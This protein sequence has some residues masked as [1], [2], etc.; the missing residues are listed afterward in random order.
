MG[1]CAS[2]QTPAEGITKAKPSRSQL[3]TTHT[4]PSTQQSASKPLSSST[5]RRRPTSVNAY[6]EFADATPLLTGRVAVVTGSTGGPMLVASTLVRKGAYVILVTT[7]STDRSS[8]MKIIETAMADAA[9]DYLRDKERRSAA[10]ET[11]L[12]AAARA[13]SPQWMR[14]QSLEAV[15]HVGAPSSPSGSVATS[16]A[17]ASTDT[18]PP[19]PWGT[20]GHIPAA[21]AAAAA[22]VRPASP[23]PLAQ[24][25]G[26]GRNGIAAVFGAK[27]R[28]G[29][30]T[31]PMAS[32][33]DDGGDA[34][35]VHVLRTPAAPEAQ[36]QHLRLQAAAGSDAAEEGPFAGARPAPDSGAAEWPSNGFS[37]VVSNFQDLQSVRDG[38]LQVL[39]I[40]RDDLGGRGIDLLVNLAEDRPRSETSK[41]Y[42]V[43]G[44]DVQVQANV[45]SHFLLTRL[46]MPALQIAAS[47]RGTARIINCTS[48][49]RDALVADVPPDAFARADDQG[50]GANGADGPEPGARANA[51]GIVPGASAAERKRRANRKASRYHNCRERYLQSRKANLVLAMALRD[52][53]GFSRSNIA[54]SVAVTG[55]H[56]SLFPPRAAAGGGGSDSARTPGHYAIAARHST[57]EQWMPVLAC[58]CLHDVHSGDIFA[59]GPPRPRCVDEMPCSHPQSAQGAAESD[60][61][62]PEKVTLEQL[63]ISIE[64]GLAGVVW[65][66]CQKAAAAHLPGKARK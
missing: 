53:L 62:V 42:S 34:V 36:L 46:L 47:S 1:I 57:M 10:T 24:R 9:Q 31:P 65:E 8:R 37:V 13:Q 2:Q 48:G 16:G 18:P 19:R 14:G 39:R 54:V 35:H 23:S 7:S 41:Q 61:G 38:A 11:A 59:A 63:G 25:R 15:T 20:S 43:D 29:G 60:I 45:V 26:V 3:S 44:Y 30:G 58:A 21:E 5:T 52:L 4:S 49:G 28:R 12:A 22:A 6:Q 66:G 33:D 64:E 56:S 32:S 55:S 51:Y 40:L 50:G 17:G 27:G